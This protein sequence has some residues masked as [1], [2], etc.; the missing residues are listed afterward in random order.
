M[1]KNTTMNKNDIHSIATVIAT[2]EDAAARASLRANYRRAKRASLSR[3]ERAWKDLFL[4]ASDWNLAP[5]DNRRLHAIAM[6]AI[7]ERW[8]MAQAMSASERHRF[9]EWRSMGYV[10]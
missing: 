3:A 5:E 2:V 4:E 8:R 7:R 9:A 6:H 1:N 10:C